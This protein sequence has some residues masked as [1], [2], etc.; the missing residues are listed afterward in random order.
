[1]SDDPSEPVAQKAVAQKAVAE[2]EQRTLAAMHE[3]DARIAELE[4]AITEERENSASLRQSL[5][6]LRFKADILERSYSK[7]LEDTRLRCVAAESELAEH[8]TRSTELDSARED[9]I[10]LLTDTKLE[11]DRL[12]TERNQLRKQLR[13][14]EG[15]VDADGENEDEDDIVSEGGTINTLLDDAKWSSKRKALDAEQEQAAKAAEQES[16][17]EEM[18]SPDLVLAAGRAKE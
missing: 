4:R 8:R 5:D 2:A 9:A 13:S 1:M 17:V 15:W 7:Q 10:Q 11:I 14:K 16:E 18:I 6:E 12:T 3:R